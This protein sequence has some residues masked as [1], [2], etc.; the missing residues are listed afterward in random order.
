M[1]RTHAGMWTSKSLAAAMAGV[2]T[3]AAC[4]DTTGPQSE[5]S[6]YLS[7]ATGQPLTLLRHDEPLGTYQVSFWAVQG[8]ERSV[9]IDYQ[10]LSPTSRADDDD[11]GGGGA[12]RFL[13]LSVPALALHRY[14]D[15][16]LFQPGDSVRITV[17]V[18]PKFVVA[19][20]SPH[21]LQFAV[22]NPAVLEI[23]YGGAS[24]DRP[25]A[26]LS[27]WYESEPG[28][29]WQPHTALHAPATARFIASLLTHFSGYAVSW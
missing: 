22:R 7:V 16:R 25:W 24:D 10:Y 23:W 18:D 14:P 13:R 27:L 15:G 6:A 1:T 12:R 8:Q 19:R 11:A 5:P 2:L 17:T 29:G 26:G 3:L 28:A 21:G 9:E 4:A 20:F